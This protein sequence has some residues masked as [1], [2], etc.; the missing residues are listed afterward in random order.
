M[1]RVIKI[2]PKEKKRCIY[3]A[4]ICKFV[5]VC[6]HLLCL[7]TFLH[8]LPSSP[9]I[10]RE[11]TRRISQAA[12]LSTVESFPRY[13]KTSC[14]NKHAAISV[15]RVPWLFVFFF[16]WFL[17]IEIVWVFILYVTFLVFPRI[18]GR[19]FLRKS[20]ILKIISPS[21]QLQGFIL[22]EKKALYATG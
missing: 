12:Y 22:R 19:Y 14:E 7:V 20:L 8:A 3:N 15:Q 11:T 4:N 6:V 16:C 10:S 18:C 9:G 1:P 13:A 5:N 17:K 2:W 21:E